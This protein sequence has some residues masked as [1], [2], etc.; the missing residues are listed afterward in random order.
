MAKWGRVTIQLDDDFVEG[1]C[2]SCPF[3]GSVGKYCSYS[4]LKKCP[5]EIIEDEEENDLDG[6]C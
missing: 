2:W 6:I 3:V 4:P 1:E 5:M